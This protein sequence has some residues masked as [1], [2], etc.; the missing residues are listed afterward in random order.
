MYI[1]SLR[2]NQSMQ[3][4]EITQKKEEKKEEM[5]NVS[6]WRSKTEMKGPKT[7]KKYS[8]SAEGMGVFPPKA[9]RCP[10][11]MLYSKCHLIKKMLK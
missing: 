7:K 9:P 2:K 8:Y 4:K 10:V 11:W 1:T 6:V 5:E 3:I